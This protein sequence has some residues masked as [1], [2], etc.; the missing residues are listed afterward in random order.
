VTD[1]FASTD[2]SRPTERPFTSGPLRVMVLALMVAIGIASV[3]SHSLEYRGVERFSKDFTIDYASA[4]ALLHG[5]D[6]YAPFREVIGSQLHPPAD[7]LRNNL[8]PGGQWHPP[9]KIVTSVPFTALPFRAAGVALLLIAAACFV[10]ATTFFGDELGW[11]RSVSVSLGFGVLALP[12]VQLDLSAGQ[13]HGPLLLLLVAA[14]RFLRRDAEL[15]A[16]ICIGLAAALKAYPGFL[17]LPLL[18]TRKLRGV[19]SAVVTAIGVNVVSM[20]WIGF[21]RFGEVRASGSEGFNYWDSSPANLSWWGL[22]TRWL[23]KNGW[24]PHLDLAFVGTAVAVAGALL[25]V[26]LAIRSS[27]S[28]L[29]GDPFW[30]AAPLML[31]AWPIV[32]DHYLI[33]A[34]PWLALAGRRVMNRGGAAV[35]AA[36]GVV[37]VGI[38]LGIPPGVAALD[39]SSGVQVALLYQLPTYALLGAV[40]IERVAGANVPDHVA[41]E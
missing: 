26:A 41:G 23:T 17:L 3:V 25:F 32:F 4:R 9:F 30:A 14:W 28:S 21:D 12:I 35:Y 10:L 8:F 39:Q 29:S 37:A 36:F 15:A 18:G 38:I 20:A 7:V 5:A 11:Q 40:V 19:V 6:P 27:S 33:L 1:R 2:P 16:G 31:L 34:I 13:I 22:S 24:V